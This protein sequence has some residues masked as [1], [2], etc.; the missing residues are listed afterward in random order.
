MRDGGNAMA[1]SELTHTPY[2]SLAVGGSSRTPQ[3]L[4]IWLRNAPLNFSQTSGDRRNISMEHF[5]NTFA[6][7]RTVS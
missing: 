4:K 1:V 7:C 2:T 5:K 6:G 3:I